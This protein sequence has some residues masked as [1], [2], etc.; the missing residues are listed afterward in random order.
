MGRT[1]WVYIITN[2]TNTVL[3]IGMTNDIVR[4]MYEHRTGTAKSSFSKKYRL[5]KLLWAQEFPTAM[6]AIAAEKK[7]KGWRREKKLQL[8]REAN[9]KFENLSLR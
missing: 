4:R 7:M 8:I 9:P 6:E 2:H 1:F 5:Y 3:Y